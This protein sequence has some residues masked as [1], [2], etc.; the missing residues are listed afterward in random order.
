MAFL[1]LE[2]LKRIGQRLDT[3]FLRKAS[4]ANNLTTTSA[5]KALDAR[6]GKA[7]K[8]AINGKT[9]KAE[10]TGSLTASGWTAS[11]DG[12]VQTI[13]QQGV[14]A[15]N[16]VIVAAAP[17]SYMAYAEHTVYCSA[18]GTNQLTFR[19]M[20]MPA[21]NLTVNVLILE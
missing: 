7:L 2:G 4:V 1:D 11:G 21:I 14:T 15:D 10:S 8:D 13:T 18:Q 3:L 19:A 16:V 9:A 20:A 6:Q 5:G 12:Y 17:D